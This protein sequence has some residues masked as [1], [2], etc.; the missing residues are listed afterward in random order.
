MSHISHDDVGQDLRRIVISGR[1]DNP[2]TDAVAAKLVELTAA[3]K[4][5]VVVD[6]S[7]I[8]FL[9]SIG[10][11]WLITS[12]KA[13]T[14]RGGKMVMV[15]DPGS[16]VMLSLEAIGIDDLIPIFAKVADAEKAALA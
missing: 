4:K 12:A 15:V 14:A 6:I 5:G 1:L 9:A 2:G 16:N 3:P 11:R 7:D 10:I 13:V 8:K